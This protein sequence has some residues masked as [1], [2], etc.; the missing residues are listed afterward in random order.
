MKSILIAVLAVG[1]IAC[2]T[3]DDFGKLSKSYQYRGKF[4]LPIGTSTLTMDN[5]P[6]DLPEHWDTIP[7]LIDIIKDDLTLSDTVPFD[8]TQNI[9]QNDKIKE[10]TFTIVSKNEFPASALVTAKFVDND[11]NILDQVTNNVNGAELNNDGTVAKAG[12]S[13][14]TD[15]LN[16]ERIQN[17]AETKYLIITTKINNN[18]NESFFK[19]YNKLRVIFESGFTVEFDFNTNSI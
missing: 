6:I 11:F 3:Q 12:T 17:M 8:F 18:V 4:A 15:T 14:N 10:L 19:H 5:Y 7:L 16:H 2:E 9:G 1:M 13:I